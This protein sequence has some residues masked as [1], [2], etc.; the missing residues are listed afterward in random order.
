[1]EM[2]LLHRPVVGMALCPG[3]QIVHFQDIFTDCFGNIQVRNNRLDVTEISVN[4]VVMM[5][6]MFMFVMVVMFVDMF[7]IMVMMV[8]MLMIVTVVMLMG[9]LIMVMM[10]VMLVIVVMVVMMP[11]I[12]I[13]IIMVMMVVV[14][15]IIMIVMVMVLVYVEALFLFSVY[16]HLQMAAPDAA[17]IHGFRSICDAGDP[18]HIEFLQHLFGIGMKFEESS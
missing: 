1:M 4:M 8:A 15:V 14:L 6:V 10:V 12:V 16:S 9:M 3:N 11:M 7:I 13:V 18:K 17:F 5:S 2:H